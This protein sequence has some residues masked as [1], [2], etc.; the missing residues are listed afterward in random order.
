MAAA[1]RFAVA[2]GASGLL[3]V[4]VEGVGDIGVEDEPHVLFVDPHAE[5]A[6]R[7]HH[8]E[9]ALEEGTQGLLAHG[10]LLPGVIRPYPQGA[11]R[12][13]RVRGDPLRVLLCGPAG[14]G[15]DQPGP[16]ELDGPLHERVP[17]GVVLDVASHREAQL[18]AVE[19]PG[20]HQGVRHGE[21]VDDLLPYGRG[22]GGG[23]RDDRRRPDP[24]ATGVQ[25]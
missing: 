9:L 18:R 1:F 23:E 2:P 3:V 16:G 4:G 7:H 25:S 11:D 13:G 8:V 15:V 6:G 10:G 24:V 20:E 19:A 17:F 12:L 22:G 21:P 14:G 5:R